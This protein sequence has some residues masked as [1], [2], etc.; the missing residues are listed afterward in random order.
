MKVSIAPAFDFSSLIIICGLQL[1]SELL[2]NYVSL[3]RDGFWDRFC[4]DLG[5]FQAL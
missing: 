2:S 1:L 3:R 5:G 4:D